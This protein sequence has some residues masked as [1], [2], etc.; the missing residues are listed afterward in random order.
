MLTNH[1]LTVG[2]FWWKLYRKIEFLFFLLENLLLKIEPSE[3]TPFFYNNFFGFGGGGVPPSPWLRLC[4]QPSCRL[5]AWWTT[6]LL[7]LFLVDS[8]ILWTNAWF[9]L[10]I[11]LGGLICSPV[12][13]SQK[14][15]IIWNS[16]I[17]LR[18]TYGEPS[19]A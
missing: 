7:D 6:F 18:C 8:T 15:R 13:K 1:A 5:I 10:E 4:L 9:S 16:L 11:S 12:S 2:K 19:H 3:I 14:L 17:A